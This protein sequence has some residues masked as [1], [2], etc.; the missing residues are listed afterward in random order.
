MANPNLP[1]NPGY[2]LYV[3]ARYVPI[4]SEI[5]NGVWDANTAYEPLTIVSYL[6]NSYTSKTFVPVGINPENTTYWALTGNYNAQLAEINNKV[7][8]ITNDIMQIEGDVSAAQAD[9][10]R[11]DGEVAQLDTELE[12]LSNSTTQSV[13]NITKEIGDIK[14]VL[15][16]KSHIL[17]G[18]KCIVV[19]D[20]L[21]ISGRWST[22][23]Q[24]ASG[25]LCKI[26]GNGSAGFTRGGRTAPWEGMN[27]SQMLTQ[28]ASTI[29]PSEKVEYSHIVIGGGINDCTENHSVEEFKSA[30]TQFINTCRTH[31]PNAQIHYFFNSTFT[32]LNDTSFTQTYETL[33]SAFNSAFRENGCA[34]YDDLSLLC[35]GRP[36]WNSGDNVHMNAAGYKEYGEAIS[37]AINGGNVAESID[38]SNRITVHP[39]FNR[40][41]SRQPPFIVRLNIL[42]VS[43]ERY[44]TGT[45]TYTLKSAPS[46]TENP[47]T[48]QGTVFN[49]GV[50]QRMWAP[51]MIVRSTTYT[52]AMMSWFGQTRPWYISNNVSDTP[53]PVLTMENGN[54][55]WY[56]NTVNMAYIQ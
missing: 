47:F 53:T 1:N 32:F 23:F 2:N 13:S 38:V 26:A 28:V 49:R 39:L 20:S 36:W 5:N 34:V 18:S 19:G 14:S 30:A 7:E 54:Q 43:F 52:M 15:P 8:T 24:N 33:K 25:A 42:E 50:S 37:N 6:G 45:E 29:S 48:V 31:F 17:Y 4:F 9:V 51:C 3:G 56:H 46:T 40:G 21:A 11:L 35:Y 41:V 44:Y 55:L 27:F 10:T 12:N 22:S 16:T